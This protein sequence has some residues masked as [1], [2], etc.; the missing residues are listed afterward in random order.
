MREH[1]LAPNQHEFSVLD[2]QTYT[3][4]DKIMLHLYGR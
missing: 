4:K 1:V 2:I 3:Q